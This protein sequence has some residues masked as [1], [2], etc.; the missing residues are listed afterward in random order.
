MGVDFRITPVYD[1]L[2]RGNEAVPYG[3]YHLHLLTA[4]QI[5]RLFYSP[6]SLKY[7]QK[8]LREL[9]EHG[10]IQIDATP[11][12]HRGPNG[13]HF[14]PLYYYALGT[15]GM[16]YLQRLGLD[17]HDSFR[18]SKEIDKH[19]LFL[20]HTFELN[21]VLIS[22]IKLHEA[23]PRYQLERLQHDRLLKR[24][25]L[26]VKVG[27]KT[28]RLIPDAF[29]AFG[30]VGRHLPLNIE[31]ERSTEQEQ[32]FK[33]RIRVYIEAIEGGIIQQR[34]GVRKVTVAFPTFEGEKRLHQMR[35]W[36]LEELGREPWEIG[37][38]FA[39]ASLPEKPTGRVSLE[40]CWYLPYPEP[41]F[42]LLG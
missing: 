35:Q 23:D 20:E 30:F 27:N 9:V 26:V 10:H 25:P 18:A 42:A 41:P 12:K 22:A 5:T 32:H 15:A 39:F 7:V 4:E 14:S 38:V 8:H 29:L 3:L 16:R 31:H 11:V 6:N 37:S 21:D 2:L 34:F 17:V 28:V 33:R 1:V 19:S 13:I 40:T 36:T 24:D